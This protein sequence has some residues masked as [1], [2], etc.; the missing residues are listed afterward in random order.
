[1]VGAQTG[2]EKTTLW[3]HLGMKFAQ[4]RCI[5]LHK[6]KISTVTPHYFL[7]I[8]FLTKSA[9]DKQSLKDFCKANLCQNA[10]IG[11]HNA[12]TRLRCW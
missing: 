1:M 2:G 11:T 7:R 3:Q 6:S 10:K 12:Y 4:K 8:T 9:K 5:L